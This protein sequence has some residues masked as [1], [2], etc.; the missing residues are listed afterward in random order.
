M[1]LNLEVP[2][3]GGGSVTAAAIEAT[4]TAANQI[5]KGTGSGMEVWSA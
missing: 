4:F 3:G 1:S 2:I 5:F